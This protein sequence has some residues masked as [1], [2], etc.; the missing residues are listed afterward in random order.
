MNASL[1][2]SVVLLL[3]LDAALFLSARF[4]SVGWGIALAAIA[5]AIFWRTVRNGAWRVT[6]SKRDRG[7]AFGAFGMLLVIA[8]LA[9]VADRG[10]DVAYASTIGLTDGTS[11][12]AL[13]GIVSVVVAKE[14]LFLR[15]LQTYLLR[16]PAWFG[17]ALLSLNFAVLHTPFFAM[18]HIFLV[19]VA[20]GASAFVLALLF[21]ATRNIIVTFL[22][23]SILDATLLVQ[24][25]LHAQHRFLEEALL[26]AILGIV[27]FLS[28]PSSRHLLAV[29][30]REPVSFAI[31]FAGVLISVSAG[32]ALLAV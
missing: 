22:V 11:L 14:E 30:R 31:A 18:Q 2:I 29:V 27:T 6:V 28:F 15:L 13:I 19:W 10:F 12:L 21:V 26:W 1:G 3:L 8:G 32:F 16:W 17:A 4:L 7:L 23:H 25:Y 24:I 5:V 9:R 20:I